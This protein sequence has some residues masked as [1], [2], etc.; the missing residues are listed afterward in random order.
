M[1]RY[2][3]ASYRVCESVT[4]HALCYLIGFDRN[5]HPPRGKL[6]EVMITME[7]ARN[8]LEFDDH[9]VIEPAFHF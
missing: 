4:W 5:W 2:S 6:H 1:V 9:F 8:T 7:D 3:F